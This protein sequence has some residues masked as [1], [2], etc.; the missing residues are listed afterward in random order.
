MDK[1]EQFKQLQEE[2]KGHGLTVIYDPLI[3]YIHVISINNIWR[4]DNG[5]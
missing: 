3:A 2:M 5:R 4:T 1:V